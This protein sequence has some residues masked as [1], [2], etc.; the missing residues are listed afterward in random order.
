MTE[1]H[2]LKGFQNSRILSIAFLKMC[3]QITFPS[4]VCS[5]VERE[6]LF[7]IDQFSKLDALFEAKNS[8]KN[9]FHFAENASVCDQKVKLRYRHIDFPY[10]FYVSNSQ[11]KKWALELFAWMN[12]D[13]LSEKVDFRLCH[14]VTTVTRW[15]TATIKVLLFFTL[16]GLQVLL[17]KPGLRSVCFSSTRG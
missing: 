9:D 2:R 17:F 1:P 6:L 14:T 11:K 3:H 16:V 15:R 7:N 10:S 5:L 12:N 13:F 8:W 4:W